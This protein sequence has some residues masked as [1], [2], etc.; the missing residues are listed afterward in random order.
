[1]T[2][3]DEI[4]KK[5]QNYDEEVALNNDNINNDNIN[6]NELSDSNEDNWK[7]I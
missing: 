7:K 2:S 6:E 4:E 3:I 1:M 5:I